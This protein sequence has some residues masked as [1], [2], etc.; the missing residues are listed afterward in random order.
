MTSRDKYVY[1]VNIYDRHS[2]WLYTLE[3]LENWRTAFEHAEEW[4]VSHGY[5]RFD[6]ENVGTGSRYAEVKEVKIYV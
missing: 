4:N 3:T 1:K 5:G 6:N 2:G